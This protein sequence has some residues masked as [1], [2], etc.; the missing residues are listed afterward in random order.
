MAVCALALEADALDYGACG[1]FAAPGVSEERSPLDAAALLAAAE[2]LADVEAIDSE[3]E[4]TVGDESESGACDGG[5]AIPRARSVTF[6]AAGDDVC[7]ITPY[8][9]IYGRHPRS[10][11]FGRHL[12]MLPITMGYCFDPHPASDSDDDDDTE[13][14]DAVDISPL[15][16]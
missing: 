6:S 2:A 15:R 10:F 11:H 8:S 4:T 1:A 3:T 5:E 9:E 12:R 14:E 16:S 13:D 7:E